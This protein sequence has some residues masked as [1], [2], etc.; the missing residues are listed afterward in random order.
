MTGL[1]Y[2]WFPRGPLSVQLPDTRT[3]PRA[4]GY[5]HDAHTVLLPHHRDTYTPLLRTTAP[6][7]HVAYTR[8]T[9][10]AVPHALHAITHT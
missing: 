6:N 7:Y 1:D 8:L 10:F 4:V 2:T 5:R 9:R 3:L